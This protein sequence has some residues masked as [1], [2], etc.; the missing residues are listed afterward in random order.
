MAKVFQVTATPKNGGIR[1]WFI[2]YIGLDGKHHRERTPSTTMAEAE[3]IL[4]KR[5]SQITKAKLTNAPAV[6]APKPRDINQYMRDQCLP[7]CKATHNS[8]KH[9]LDLSLTVVHHLRL[10]MPPPITSSVVERY[11][12]QQGSATGVEGTAVNK[13]SVE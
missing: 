11:V 1:P 6:E 5:M 8:S 4:L 2:P 7:T 13:Q 12:G 9:T 10:M 3:A